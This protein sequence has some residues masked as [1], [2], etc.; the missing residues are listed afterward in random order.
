MSKRLDALS[1]IIL[2][3]FRYQTPTPVVKEGE[4]LRYVVTMFAEDYRK[5]MGIATAVGG[6]VMPPADKERL[7]IEF[8]E[9]AKTGAGGG[10]PAAS[11]AGKPAATPGIPT[12]TGAAEPACRPAPCART[13]DGRSPSLRPHTSSASRT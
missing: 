13:P 6:F 4:P 7:M 5:M 2:R 11:P 12:Q 10:A 3:N 9:K 1:G 8:A